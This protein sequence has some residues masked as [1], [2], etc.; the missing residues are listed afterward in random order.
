[1]GYSPWISH[2]SELVL[3]NSISQLHSDHCTLCRGRLAYTSPT[4]APANC[5]HIQA[6][7]GMV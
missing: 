2:H 7:D 4:H 3:S 5:Q 1:M 6:Q